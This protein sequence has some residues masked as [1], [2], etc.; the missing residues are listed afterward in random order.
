MWAEYINYI[1]SCNILYRL[2]YTV[3]IRHGNLKKN[4]LKTDKGGISQLK[5]RTKISER[6][7]VKCPFLRSKPYYLQYSMYSMSYFEKKIIDSKHKNK[8]IFGLSSL[9]S[10][11]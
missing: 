4:Y 7:F 10:M 3:S 2:E 9:Y 8:Y 6:N 11:M 5:Y 1:G